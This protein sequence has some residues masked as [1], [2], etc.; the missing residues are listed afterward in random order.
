MQ[1]FIAKCKTYFPGD[2]IL[3][4]GTGTGLMSVY[5]S[6]LGYNV[7]GLDYDIEIVKKNVRFNE[8]F[9]GSAAFLNGDKFSLPFAPNTFDACYHQGLME[10]FDEPDILR[11]LRGQVEVCQRVVFTVPTVR[12]KGGVF[13][14]ERMWTGHH[15]LK[16]LS[17]FEI[18][19]VFG[20]AYA[21][22]PSRCLNL[23]GR[24]MTH[25][26]PEYLYRAIALRRAGDIGFV[27]TKR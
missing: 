6:Q 16:L 15:W 4:I 9:R 20:G 2:T 13:G 3:E 7:T 24:R 17:E 12:W 18:L 22:L 19:D 1:P 8:M 23:I 10:H 27:L 21:D 5:F 14:N 26:K 11:S 25:W